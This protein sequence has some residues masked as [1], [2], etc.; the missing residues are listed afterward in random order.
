ML[1]LRMHTINVSGVKNMDKGNKRIILCSDGT[2]NQGGFGQDS[3]VYKL[4]KSIEIHNADIEQLTFYENG[5]GTNKNK[6]FRALSGGLGF[7]FGQNVRDLYEFL[8]RHYQIGDEIYFF[9]FSRGAATA[10]ATIG[11]IDT[12]G[13]V[14]LA[15]YPEV[16]DDPKAMDDLIKD[17]FKLY[18]GRKKNPKAAE[19]FKNNSTFHHSEYAADGCLQ[20]KFL[21]VW[22]TVSALGF[23]KDG[24]WLIEKFF[25]QVDILSDSLPFCAHNFYNYRV[26]KQLEYA[27]QALAIDDERATFKPR[28]WKDSR[29]NTSEQVWFSGVHSNVGGGYPRSGMSNVALQWMMFKALESGLVFQQDVFE[30]VSAQA[31]ELGRL[32]DSRSGFGA[33][34]RY[35]PRDIARLN[36]EIDADK[37]KIHETVFHRIDHAIASYA[38][39]NI[40]EDFAIVSTEKPSATREKEINARLKRIKKGN[41]ERINVLEQAK[42]FIALRK[43]LYRVMVESTLALFVIAAILNPVLIPADASDLTLVLSKVMNFILPGFFSNL[44]NYLSLHPF[45]LFLLLCY[46]GFLFYLRGCF[47]NETAKLHAKAGEHL[48]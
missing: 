29:A 48:K 23:P 25:E 5:V 44:V 40:P 16:I 43:S 1:A 17:I 11:F 38:P 41:S 30:Q 10:R 24:S 46:L 13:L 20:I 31:N 9:G 36:A 18:E 8:A 4:Y 42:K 7:G 22:D 27:Y 6:I 14:D 45:Y 2:G 33:Y 12:C 39:G 3:N 19:T 28:I 15:K 34:Y 37:V 26:N 35:Q 32:Y 47:H 21:G